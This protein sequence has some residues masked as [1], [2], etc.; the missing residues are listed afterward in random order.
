[1]L[2]L[3]PLEPRGVLFAGKPR[4]RVL[5]E[6]E[7]VRGMALPH[8][9]LLASVREMLLRVRPHRLEHR[10]PVSARLNQT[11]VDEGLERI[12][13]RSAYGLDGVQGE[14]SREGGEPGEQVPF[15]VSEQIEAPV[16]GS[17]E[18]L[19]SSRQVARSAAQQREPIA[20]AGS[21]CPGESSFARGAP[22]DDGEG[23]DETTSARKV[24]GADEELEPSSNADADPGPAATAVADDEREP[25]LPASRAIASPRN[26]RRSRR[27]SSIGLANR[28]SRRTH[29]SP[30]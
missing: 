15:F 7:D 27:D 3:E 17:A 6:G 11:V 2:G 9:L 12:D 5:P 8:L 26:G 29:S 1:M 22:A 25:L 13:G 18:R 30:T 21:E 16:E 4:R 14:S 10:A 23:L 28:S 24:A 19:V 20:E